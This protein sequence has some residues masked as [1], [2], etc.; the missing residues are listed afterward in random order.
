MKNTLAFAALVALATEASAISIAYDTEAGFLGA[1][2]PVYY[3]NDFDDIVAGSLGIASIDYNTEPFKYTITSPGG[4]F[5][6]EPGGKALSTV[7]SGDELMVTFTSGNVT[8]VGGIF[9][10]T[11]DPGNTVSGKVKVSLSDGTDLSF[12]AGSFRGFTSSSQL[13]KSLSVSSDA[14]AYPTMDHFYAGRVPDGGTTI[15]LLGGALTGLGALR[16]KF[17]R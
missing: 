12:D 2:N 4:L 10:L 17:R 11:D 1:I 16:R 5:G 15:V 13:I 8:A 9:F 7:N 14:S 3:L 6:V